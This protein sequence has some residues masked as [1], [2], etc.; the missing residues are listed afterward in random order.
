MEATCIDDLSS[1][2]AEMQTTVSPYSAGSVSLATTLAGEIHRLRFVLANALGWT[3]WYLRDSNIDF[4]HTATGIQGSGLGRHVTAVALHTWSGFRQG[5]PR[6]AQYPAITS[7]ADHWTGIAWPAVGHMSVVIGDGNANGGVQGGIEAYRFHAAAMTLHHT[8]ALRFAHST[9]QMGNG[10][11]GHVTAIRLSRVAGDGAPNS[12]GFQEGND[13]LIFGH[14]ASLLAFEG[15][16]YVFRTTAGE[17]RTAGVQLDI[18]GAMA[19]SGTNG[20]TVRIG[21]ATTG[22]T[23]N[24]ALWVDAGTTRLDGAATIGD[25]TSAAGQAY[26]KSAAAGTIGLVVDTAASP[27]ANA[28]NWNVNNAN[29]GSMILTDTQATFR[30][31]AFGNGAGAG[32]N[33][34][35]ARNSDA[36]TPAAGFLGLADRAGTQQN[37]WPDNTGKLRISSLSPTNANDV[38]GTVVG[39]QTSWWEAKDVLGPSRIDPAEALSALLATQVYDF[40]Y[41]DGAYNG[42]TFTGLVGYQ[43]NDWFLKNADLSKGQVPAL[44]EVTMF[45]Y[46]TL[47]IKE[48]TRRIEALEARP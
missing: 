23:N 46:T 6:P 18:P 30:L 3:D 1:N 21:A 13:Q 44:D 19:T 42:R 15:G 5:A 38:A 24:Y 36:T 34:V 4:N 16:A 10:Q 32:T 11:Y 37:I 31:E 41:R 27:S 39:D 33:L 17:A 9:S 22:A 12:F 26:I 7:V 47:A 43:A 2:T 28:Q 8:A 45:G 14:A 35:A 25:P 20:A 48:L 40:R 29:R